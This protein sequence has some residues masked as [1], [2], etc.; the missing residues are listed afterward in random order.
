MT[1]NA[2]SRGSIGPVTPHAEQLVRRVVDLV[3]AF[4]ERRHRDRLQRTLVDIAVSL[5]GVD[6]AAVVQRLEDGRLE[7][8]AFSS[9]DARHVTQVQ[10]QDPPTGPAAES[11]AT[12]QP[13]LL[14]RLDE[15]DAAAPAFSRAALDAGFGYAYALPLGRR[16][17]ILGSV[18]LY[19]ADSR[20]LARGERT[21]LESMTEIVAIG[22]SQRG[23]LEAADQR[24]NQLERALATRVLIEQAKGVLL[25]RG[26][27]DL[28]G[29]YEI[30]RRQARSRHVHLQ[31]AA[32]DVLARAGVPGALDDLLEQPRS[33]TADDDV[34]RS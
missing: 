15:P 18:V 7:V 21:I 23:T 5:E 13:I 26:D 19:G 16:S 1:H 22:L 2:W 24:V 9:E 25:A 12:G 3:G 14:H 11:A 10:L 32:R 33:G 29:A 17:R 6:G 31:D 27:V 28:A 34:S 20:D 30:L 8:S 4:G